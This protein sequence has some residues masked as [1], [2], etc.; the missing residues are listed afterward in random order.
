MATRSE[1]GS[2]GKGRPAAVA[3]LFYPQNPTALAHDV[4]LMLDAALRRIPLAGDMFPKAIITPHAGYKYSG[5]I[6][7][8]VW[9]RLENVCNKI[10]KVVLIGP[11]H[12]VALRGLALPDAD[13]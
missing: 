13:Y 1:T 7:A 6:A 9:S 8:G 5:A 3:G 11:S 12:R 2:L 10:K 4:Q